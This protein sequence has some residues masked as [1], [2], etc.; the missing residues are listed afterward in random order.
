MVMRL[1]FTPYYA[2]LATY[3]IMVFLFCGAL[4]SAA[5]NIGHRAAI[6]AQADTF[7]NQDIAQLVAMKI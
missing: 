4:R 2:S 6:D 5:D 1:K 7:M 3:L